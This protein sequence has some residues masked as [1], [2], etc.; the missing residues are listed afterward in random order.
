MSSLKRALALALVM[1]GLAAC[2]L[3]PSYLSLRIEA[4]SL[5]AVKTNDYREI[6][7]TD[8][9]LP[10]TS[11]DINLNQELA[12][13][14]RTEVSFRFKGPV[15]RR[16]LILDKEEKLKD[17]AFWKEAA[18]GAPGILFLTGKARLEQELRKALLDKDTRT[19]EEPFVQEKTWNERKSFTLQITLLL[20][21]GGTGRAIFEKEYKETANYANTKQPVSFALFD[22]LQQ[23]KLKF[24][25]TVFGSDRLQD[26]YLIFR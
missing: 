1:A 25:R 2:S 11:P 7:V 13:Y 4:S 9:F 22:M 5:P 24:F 8:F 14:F 23:L 6:A 26:R 3:D 10:D 18:S 16:S 15:S 12:E 20:I 21:D 17:E 19:R